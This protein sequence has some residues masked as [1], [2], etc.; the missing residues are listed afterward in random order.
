MLVMRHSGIASKRPLGPKYR[1]ISC[2]T[3]YLYLGTERVAGLLRH[4][5]WVCK[6]D[7]RIPRHRDL[8]TFQLRAAVAASR[9]D[10]QWQ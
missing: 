4:I 7:F 3:Q 8:F 5:M 9:M 1:T 2:G 6:S 10:T